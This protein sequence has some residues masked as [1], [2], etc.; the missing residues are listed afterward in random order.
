M[1]L[2]AS[3]FGMQQNAHIFISGPPN[4]NLFHILIRDTEN[5]RLKQKNKIAFFD[6]YTIFDQK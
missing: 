4:S 2:K 3:K 1:F 5:N 6:K